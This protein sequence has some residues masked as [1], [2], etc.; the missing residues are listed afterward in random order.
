MSA[1]NVTPTPAVPVASATGVPVNWNSIHV[2]VFSTNDRWTT[3]VSE[4]CQDCSS[5]WE[6][7]LC[8]PCQMGYQYGF[9][10]KKMRHCSLAMCLMATCLPCVAAQDLRFKIRSMYG[11][12]GNCCTDCMPAWCCTPCVVSQNYRE[13]SVRGQ[14]SGGVLICSPFVRYFPAPN[15]SPVM[16]QPAASYQAPQLAA[17]AAQPCDEETPLMPPTKTVE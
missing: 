16:G 13:I 3:G 4:C 9:V 7:F 10:E 11:I 6:S 17:V 12:K 5:C 2:P 14:W 15:P 8:T 1:M